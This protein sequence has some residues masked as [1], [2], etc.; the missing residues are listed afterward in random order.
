MIELSYKNIRVKIR[1]H[2]AELR[3]F[4]NLETEIEHMWHADPKFWNKSAP[5][6]FPIVGQV[7]DGEYF[8]DGNRYEM[9]QHGFARDHVFEVVKSTATSAAF[10]FSYSEDSLKIYPYKF[11]L[12]INYELDEKGLKVSY[13][14]INKDTKTIYFQLGAHPAFSC[15]FTENESFYDHKVLFN[16]KVTKDQLIFKDGLLTGG[17]NEKY[18]DH[19]DTMNLSPDT[20]N[21]DAVII[22]SHDLKWVKIINTKG[23]ELRMD[24]EGWPLLGIWSKPR[25]NAPFLC[26]EPWFGVASVKGE[27]KE[28]KD[29]KAMQSL[30]KEKTFTASYLISCQ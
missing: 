25:I 18:L 12:R 3:S 23:N 19:T 9:S 11:E 16:E 7:E 26:L 24:M 1:E 17:V 15:P 14:V 2:G 21:D 13:E 10:S 20:F 28:F 22:E 5:V 8:I 27:S 4:Y 30:E 29:K 6:L